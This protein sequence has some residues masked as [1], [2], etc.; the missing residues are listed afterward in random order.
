[1]KLKAEELS[2]ALQKPLP[3]VWLISGDEPLLV[4]ECM[5]AL[6]QTAKAQGYLERVILEVDR[7]FDW[8]MLKN[9]ADTLSLFAE[10]KLT[11]LRLGSAK[12]GTPGS[13]AIIDYCEHL[14]PDTLLL[15]ESAKL[16]SS[17][18]KSKWIQ[19]IEKAGVLIQV[20]PVSINDMP[21]WLEQRA[22]RM[23]LRLAPECIALLSHRL[24]GNLLAASQELEKLK[25]LHGD[26]SI[27]P[28]MIQSE[29]ADSS[30]YDVFDLTDA[31]ILGNAQHAIKILQQL[32]HEGIDAIRILWALSREIRL[33]AG[34]AHAA[35]KSLPEASLMQKYR[36][37]PRRQP[38]LRSAAKRL[39]LNTFNQLLITCKTADDAIKGIERHK[40]VWSLLDE[41]VVTLA[42]GKA[43]SN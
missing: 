7:S 41:V 16:D 20:W 21:R 5:D 27:S 42:S 8:Q 32:Q 39:S 1:M 11:E 2:A 30:R 14:P 35:V 34:L 18:L 28:E 10:Q 22:R 36:V 43:L 3:P 40:D 17:T 4:Q 24:E 23:K 13:K 33:L 31:C 15:I 29:V 38:A 25:L 37:L 19:A 9:E 6:R 26:E 12:P